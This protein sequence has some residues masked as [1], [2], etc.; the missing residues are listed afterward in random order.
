MSE[1]AKIPLAIA[2]NVADRFIKYITPYCSKVCVA[3]SI[4]RECEYVGDVEVV[5]TALD[6]FSLSRCFPEGFK[7]MVV[8][9]T[10]LKRF[11]YPESGIQIEMYVTNERDWGRI[12]AIRTGSSAFAYIQLAMTWNRMGLC[13]TID[14]L[15]YKRECEKRGSIWK[16]KSEFKSNPTK[17]P[18][19]PTEE[20]FFK[21]LQI[22]WI[23][24]KLRSWVSKHSEI[25]Y[26]V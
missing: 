9:G 19:F 16:L 6:E 10:R 15:R 13:G 12:L 5:V 7:G 2:K 18:E 24:P 3:G 21:F 17:P 23:E 1:G 14:G 4:R 11:K 26:A 22:P 20:S 8:N 25:N